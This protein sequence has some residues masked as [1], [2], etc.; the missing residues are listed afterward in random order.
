MAAPTV[1]SRL[2][3]LVDPDGESP[4]GT[5]FANWDKVDLAS[6]VQ[7][8]N[9]GQSAPMPFEGALVAERDTGIAYTLTS[10][11]SGGWTKKYFVYPYQYVSI[12]A[13]TPLPTTTSY[14]QWGWATDLVDI[15]RYYVNSGSQDRGPGNSWKV[16]IKGIYQVT[17][18]NRWT[19]S[20]DNFTLAGSLMVN[21]V[22]L[23]NMEMREQSKSAFATT[24]NIQHQRLFNAGDRV[25][26]LYQMHAPSN[27]QSLY[28]SIWA[29]MIRPV[30]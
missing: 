11:G 19:G 6:G 15:S 1:S 7:H 20:T 30:A 29:T 3:L 13:S 18:M 22:E 21:D 25:V 5:S 24:L 27:T 28:S 12:T 14:A 16:P 10:D 23:W 4:I 17:V 2:K 26:G 9:S 8:I